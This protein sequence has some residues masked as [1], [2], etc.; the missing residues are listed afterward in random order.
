MPNLYSFIR[1]VPLA[2]PPSATHMATIPIAIIPLALGAL[3][4]RIAPYTFLQNDSYYGMQLVRYL[5]VQLILGDQSTDRLYR[6]LDSSLNGVEYL[7]S[8]VDSQL[9]ITPAIPDVPA[10]ASRSIHSRL[11]RLE[12]LSDNALNG[13]IHAP[14][15]L[16]ALGIR[17]QLADL[18]AAIQATG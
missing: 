7:A 6:L 10:A 13:A 11:E 2:E 18:V 8:T 5:Q 3:E 1:H 16:N 14:D 12:Y 15:F 17:Q 9:V 4:A